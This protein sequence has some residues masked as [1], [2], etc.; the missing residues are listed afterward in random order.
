MLKKMG[1][2]KKKARKGDIKYWGMVFE[3]LDRVAREGISE[4][5]SFK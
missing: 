1:K 5:V 2:K 3:I 4:K